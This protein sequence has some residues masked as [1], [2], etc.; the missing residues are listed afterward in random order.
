MVYIVL[1]LYCEGLFYHSSD[2][3]Y[4]LNYCIYLR[5]SIQDKIC[6][7]RTYVLNNKYS[8]E[9]GIKTRPLTDWKRRERVLDSLKRV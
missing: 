7:S 8:R 5:I 9:V 6:L 2:E 1:A 4:A 3:I